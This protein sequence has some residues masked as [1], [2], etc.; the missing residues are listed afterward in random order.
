MFYQ[1]GRQ[2][3]AD[4]TLSYLG[5]RKF[6]GCL[7]IALPFV[8]LLGKIVFDG[9]GIEPTI[10][11]Y[12]YTVMRDV[13]VGLL[14]AIGIFLL[15]YRG[16]DRSDEIAGDIAGCAAIGVAWA[17][18]TPAVIA[19]PHDQLLGICHYVFAAVFFATLAYFCLALFRK[20]DSPAAMKPRKKTRN[21]VYT[22]CGWVILAFMIAIAVYKFSGTT[23][24]G[25]F[26]LV[27]VLETVMIL[28]FG[29]SWLIKGEALL[30]D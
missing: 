6:I 3:A 9:S 18:T 4:Y 10:S 7:G 22:V 16:Y 8:V 1:I 24:F 25:A 23:A 12:Y 11:D 29:I 15:S 20:T 17:P 30:K 14:C 21:G 28:A 2:S 27:F 13:F 26:P 5:L 19:G